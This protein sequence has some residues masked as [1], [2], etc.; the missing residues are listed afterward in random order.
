MRPFSHRKASTM[1]I[2]AIKK[3]YEEVIEEYRSHKSEHI[4]PKKPNIFFRTLLKLV[5]VPDLTSTHFN[6]EKIGMDKL[7]RK[8]PALF[9]MNHSS[10]IDLEIVASALYPRSFNI[11][12]T[13]DGFIGKDWLMRHIGCIPTKKFVAD[14]TS[15]RDIMHTV[16]NL[17]SSIVMFPEAGYSLDG[18]ATTLPDTLGS[19]VKMLDIPLVMITTYGAFSRDPLYNNL[20]KRKVRV[21]A[22][23]EYLLDR[24]QIH[25]MPADEINA[26]I[27]EKF[28][29]DYFKWQQEHHVRIGEAFRADGLE[30]ALYK[31]PDC[32]KEG[33]MHGEGITLKCLE[34]GKTHELNEYG[35]L[36][37]VT[38]DDGFTHV[39]DWYRWEREEV[40][41]EIEAGEYELD[42][43]VNVWIS[44]DT[45]KLYDI[46]EGRLR[47][48]ID[49]F[50]LTDAKGNL[51]Y[52]HKPLAS[53]SICA[54]F[55]FYEVG[56]VISIANPECIYYCFPKDQTIPVAKA[57]LAAEEI[58]KIKYEE[59]LAARKA[60]Q[61][62]QG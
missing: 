35:S 18:T 7:G 51:L 27:H 46:G 57:R 60:K 54:D 48:T 15:V 14:T 5:S 19:F 17:R 4:K 20:Q 31:C 28:G 30:R 50:A 12:T 25:A 61:D 11:V 22:T 21:S 39:P 8:E 44:L 41:K 24:D 1:K 34:C 43:P 26:L 40:R 58:Y 62:A 10:F 29:F 56:D 33:R 59:K 47:H 9:L 42:T 38:S 2:K 55:N 36:I 49:G 45:K 53:Y 32:G 13:T 23:V 52:E 16:K 3:P 6:C 37:P